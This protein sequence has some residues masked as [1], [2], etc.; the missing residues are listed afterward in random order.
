[1][2]Q[3]LPEFVY[4]STDGTVTTFAVI[5]GAL[6]AKLSRTAVL[7]IG[8]ASVIADGY[9][10][11]VSSYLSES[12]R[13]E[14]RSSSDTTNSQQHTPI[15]SGIIT[16]LSFVSIGFIPLLPFIISPKVS[17]SIKYTSLFLALSIFAG[18]G[19]LRGTITHN[20][21]PM[22]TSLESFLI[23]GSAALISYLTGVLVGH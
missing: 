4:G 3:F 5:A 2:E 10:M 12:A 11:G 23:G 21:S 18:I 8:I 6:G 22:M 16:F 17:D 19:Y 7:A 9:S 13:H 15:A 1:M 20:Q 14:Q